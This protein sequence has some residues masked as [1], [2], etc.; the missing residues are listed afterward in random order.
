VKKQNIVL[1]GFR[2]IGKARF[3]RA[4]AKFL[5]LPFADLDTEVEFVLGESI[6]SF[7][8]KFGWQEFRAVEQRVVHDFSRNFSG[9][10][11]TG[12]GTIEN[13]K[14]LQN[15]KKNGFFVFLNPSF[16]KVRK[17]LISESGQENYRRVTPEMSLV[18]EIDQLWTQR[19]DIYSATAD[20]EVVPDFDGNEEEEAKKMVAQL[21]EH[22]LPIAPAPK[23]VAIFSSSNGSTM[24]GLFEAQAK[25]RIPNVEFVLF[26]TDKE[27]SGALKK[28]QEFGI[29]QTTVLTPEKDE[30]REEYDRTLINLLRNKQPDIVLLAGWMR[31]LSPLFCEQFG[32][33]TWNVHP[34]LLPDHAG[35][36]GDAVHKE[37]LNDGDRYTGCSV[38][39][40]SAQVD[41]GEMVLQRKIPVAEDDTVD[42][43]RVKVQ[44]QEVLGF[45]EGLERR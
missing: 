14:N 43:L 45:C 25:G 16:M 23:K 38:H 21:P 42:S 36:K 10:I 35:L 11:A 29:K 7:V 18:Q 15:L 8:G 17:F 2:G 37:V 6:E 30:T 31:I 41:A 20:V 12:E 44:R 3:G 40:V 28:A 34:S 39:R 33:I 26:V 1:V 4:I 13:S 22:I 32:P 27:D 9:V 5:G 24:K 19:K